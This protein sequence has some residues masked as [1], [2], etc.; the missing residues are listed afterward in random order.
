MKLLSLT[1]LLLVTGCS[2]M[3]W[4]KDG[5]TQMDFDRDDYRC[6]QETMTAYSGTVV[7]WSPQVATAQGYAAPDRNMYQRCMRASGYSMRGG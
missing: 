4:D 3:V 6:R 1:M 2:T 5:A 7:R